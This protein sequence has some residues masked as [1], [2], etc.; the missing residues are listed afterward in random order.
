MVRIRLK[1]LGRRH[2]PCYRLAAFDARAPRGGR[3]IDE[4]LG[5]Y[6]PLEAD[7]D[8]KVAL[9]RERILHWLDRGAQ[10]SDAVASILKK[11]GIHIDRRGHARRRKRKKMRAR[12]KA[13]Q[14]AQ[15]S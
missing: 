9:N 14:A 2:R 7:N 1:R 11:N 10:P 8:K 3:A 15:N 12:A 5:T 4:S 6:D 13:Q